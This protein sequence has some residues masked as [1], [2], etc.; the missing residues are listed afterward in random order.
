VG[1]SPPALLGDLATRLSWPWPFLSDVERSLYARLQVGRGRLRDV[2]SAGTV[3]RYV[4]AT[5][6]GVRIRKPVE[7]T[8]QLGADAVVMAGR[9]VWVYR[10]R[11]PDDRPTTQLLLDTVREVSRAGGQA[12]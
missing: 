12:R 2:Y 8:R 6:R 11:S 10:P 9:A 1:F 3:R 4:E 7:D 5:R